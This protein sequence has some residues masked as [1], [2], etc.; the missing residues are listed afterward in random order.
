MPL[1][2]LFCPENFAYNKKNK[3]I[4]SHI[5]KTIFFPLKMYFPPN[6]KAWL[7]GSLTSSHSAKVNCWMPLTK[8]FAR[9]LQNLKK[10]C[11]SNVGGRSSLQGTLG[12]DL[13][14]RFETHISR[15]SR[16]GLEGRS[17]SRTYC[18]QALNLQRYSMERLRT[19]AGSLFCHIFAKEKPE[20]VKLCEYLTKLARKC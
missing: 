2:Y 17:R 7:R 5:I 13:E 15:R 6:L 3:Y 14:T 10:F 8:L 9:P 19:A 12:L 18:L 11:L 20:K 4:F 1:P 16:L